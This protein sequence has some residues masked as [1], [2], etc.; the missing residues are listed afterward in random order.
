MVVGRK[1]MHGKVGKLVNERLA[2]GYEPGARLPRVLVHTLPPP[3]APEV[4]EGVEVEVLF[5]EL[6][7][8]DVRFH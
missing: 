7:Y 6:V 3:Q 8:D 5:P 4:K 2:V 1:E